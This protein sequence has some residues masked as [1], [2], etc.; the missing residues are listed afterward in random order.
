MIVIAISILMGGIIK[1][2]PKTFTATAALMVDPEA[3]ILW[4]NN[5]GGYGDT[6]VQL[7]V[8]RIAAHGSAAAGDRQIELDYKD[9]TAGY[10]VTAARCADRGLRKLNQEFGYSARYRQPA[11]LHQCVARSAQLAAEKLP[12]PWRTSI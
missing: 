1:L 6:H 10:S 11:D 4:E 7:H 12:I 9:Y 8:H 2:M 5:Q 3:T